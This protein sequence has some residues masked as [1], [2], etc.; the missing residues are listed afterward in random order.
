[1]ELY[2][3]FYITTSLLNKKLDSVS[4][5][6]FETGDILWNSGKQNL[7]EFSID[8][9]DPCFEGDE[10]VKIVTKNPNISLK[11][12]EIV[13]KLKTSENIYSFKNKN[14]PFLKGF[15]KNIKNTNEPSIIFWQDEFGRLIRFV[16]TSLF[17][18][19]GGKPV[20]YLYPQKEEN[21]QILL[22]LKHGFSITR[23]KYSNGWNVLANPNGNLK[24]LKTGN[25]YSYLFWEG[26]LADY[27]MP[28]EGFIVEKE[29]IDNFFKEKLSYIGLN[30]KE[31][32]DF[33]DFWVERMKE[34]HFYFITF[35]LNADV[36]KLA[37]LS[38]TPKPNTI[39][40]ILMDYKPIDKHIKVREQKLPKINRNGFV[41]VEWGGILKY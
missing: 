4:S 19:C 38:I 10:Y 22:N 12:L 5:I 20:I 24:D 6:Q 40:R 36:D 11:D 41:V 27:K 37:P 32:N 18:F 15:P 31:I 3:K 16:N 8:P 1:M 9:I 33:T 29:N 2:N 14:H 13:G 25:H 26:E 7:N 39:I 35:T 17:N 21:I 30:T 34:K 23:P 28:Q